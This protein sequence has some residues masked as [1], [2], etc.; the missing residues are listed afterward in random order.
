MEEYCTV[1]QKMPDGG[2]TLADI[3]YVLERAADAHAHALNI[4]FDRMYR[5]FSCLWMIV[6]SAVRL[7][8]Q[9][10]GELRVTTWLRRPSAV[11]STRDFSVSDALGELGEATELWVLVDAE[12][13]RLTDMRRIEPL[14]TLPAPQPERET[15]PPRRLSLPPLSPAGFWT[16]A[17]E[18]IDKNGHLN[19]VAYIRHAQEFAPGGCL[20]VAAM[21]DRECFAGE[22]LTVEAA[23]GFVRI[24]RPDGSESFRCRFGE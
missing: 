8:R 24:T 23:D 17:P 10:Q 6:R 1:T 3:L 5:D 20:S 16:V 11:A 2:W 14:W 7:G 13:R 9:P 22:C 12:K 4:D 19:N 15:V 21:Y 18:E